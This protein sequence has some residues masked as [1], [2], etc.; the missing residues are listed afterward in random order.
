MV[1]ILP[2]H[3]PPICAPCTFGIAVANRVEAKPHCDIKDTGHGSN[4]NGHGS[5]N[6]NGHG[7]NGNGSNG[8]S[9]NKNGGNGNS[10]TK[11][12]GNGNGSNGNGASTTLAVDRHYQVG[13]LVGMSLLT[14]LQP[15]AIPRRR[16][17]SPVGCCAE[18]CHTG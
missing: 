15:T 11:G 5:N 9:D 17:A 7:S 18:T 2:T 1:L 6:G 14:S 16:A 12:D 13:G 4:G 8:S 10:A 3:L